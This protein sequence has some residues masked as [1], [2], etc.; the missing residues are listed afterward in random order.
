[1]KTSKTILI[2]LMSAIVLT[3]S[4]SAVFA[5]FTLATT[6]EKYLPGTGSTVAVQHVAADMTAFKSSELRVMAWDGDVASWAFDYRDGFLRG[7]FPLGQNGPAS[8]GAPMDPDVVV[9]PSGSGRSI[10]VYI[11]GNTNQIY[12][13]IF[14]YTDLGGKVVDAPKLV[15][16]SPGICSS[17]NVDVS[18]NGDVVITWVQDGDVFARRF[19]FANDLYPHVLKVNGNDPISPANGTCTSADVAISGISSSVN[20]GNY[21]VDIVYNSDLATKSTTILQRLSLDEITSGGKGT[22]NKGYGF[23]KQIMSGE[24][25]TLGA[26]R[27]AAPANGALSPFDFTVVMRI[28]DGIV[29]HIVA[30]THNLAINGFDNV[31]YHEINTKPNDLSTCT[32]SD[33]VVAYVG[34]SII[35]AW[36]YT[37]TACALLNGDQDVI[38]RQLDLSGNWLYPDYSV[39]DLDINGNQLTPAISG[40]FSTT[41]LTFYAYFDQDKRDI[42]YKSSEFANL[43]LKKGSE[44]L[45]VAETSME[46]YPIPMGNE[47]TLNINIAKGETPVSLNVYNLSG[48]IVDQFDATSLNEGNNLITWNTKQE[49]ID[50]GVYLIRL[51]TDKTTKSI[52]V[53]KAN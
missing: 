9:D 48:Q 40:R 25:G 20:G 44:S 52:T 2:G 49:N 7:I 21:M 46:A 34:N 53:N 10:V 3:F 19:S 16:P 31:V 50:A 6:P 5:Q 24:L 30:L 8:L 36:T 37:D 11:D 42:A 18:P 23:T 33:P 4:S 47:A 32:N 29:D 12:R 26:P 15:N 28:S 13:E 38:V 35:T 1:M 22:K 27:I 43:S 39:A 45:P 14:E 41:G 51:I 17:P